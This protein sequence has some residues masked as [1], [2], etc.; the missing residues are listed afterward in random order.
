MSHRN[1]TA[2]LGV[3]FKK[4]EKF[5]D[6]Y[7]SSLEKQS[8]RDFDLI[9]I[10]DGFEGLDRYTS[11][12]ELSVRVWE[13]TNT[14]AKIR[15]YAINRIKKERYRYVVFTDSDDFYAQN[16]IQICVSLLKKHDIVVND[17]TTVSQKEK[18]LSQAYFSKRFRD[19]AMIGPEDLQ[20]GNMLGFSNTGL[21]VSCLK[22]RISFP[23]KMIS[24]D[25]FFFANLLNQGRKAIFTNKTI[26][27]Y[28]LYGDNV[29]GLQMR[30]TEQYIKKVLD[31]KCLYY[32]NLSVQRKDSSRLFR[33]FSTLRKKFSA[34]S[35][36]RKDYID[37][38]MT[39]KIENPLWWEEIRLFREL[40]LCA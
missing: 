28:R 24:A 14:P 33:L 17:L 8:Y 35:V 6:K 21:R 10:N 29:A 39:Q 23:K 38:L 36:F 26:S 34:N 22:E 1:S 5:I 20:C 40:R 13:Y 3:V 12:Y 32:K 9:L 11:K 15:Q 16:R 31:I 2:V 37:R 25:W 30:L 27:F 18:V 19:G 7:L 4:N